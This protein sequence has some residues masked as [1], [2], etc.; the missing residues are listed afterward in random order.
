MGV[1]FCEE[2][3]ETRESDSEEFLEIWEIAGEVDLC[4]CDANRAFE[5][6]YRLTHA[7]ILSMCGRIVAKW[8][9]TTKKSTDRLKNR[10]ELWWTF[11][12]TGGVSIKPVMIWFSGQPRGDPPRVRGGATHFAIEHDGTPS[13]F[14]MPNDGA[15][16]CGARNRDSLSVELINAC[17]LTMDGDDRY[18]WWAGKYDLSY[19]PAHFETPWRGVNIWQPY[20]ERQFVALAKLIRLSFASMGRDRF[21]PARMAEHYQFSEKRVDCGPMFPREALISSV[22]SPAP[23]SEIPWIQSFTQPSDPSWDQDTE[24]SPDE[25]EILFSH[26]ID[27][28]DQISEDPEEPERPAEKLQQVLCC[29]GHEPGSSGFYD[30]KTR[31]AVKSFQRKWNDEHSKKK[32]AV[33]GIAGP[34]TRRSIT[35]YLC[36]LME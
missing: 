17:K 23:L 29:L 4:C 25:L 36:E 27:I 14:I 7:R 22:F 1:E 21:S 5:L 24:I 6:L 10:D 35:K 20:D 9:P 19:S 30:R 26:A 31:N 13:C 28:D 34:I 33:D 12:A 15:R 32:I 16:H 18:R 3:I 8:Y 2:C 11:H